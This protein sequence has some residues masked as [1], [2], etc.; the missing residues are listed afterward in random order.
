TP[1]YMVALLLS[2]ILGAA[3]VGSFHA[4][5]IGLTGPGFGLDAMALA[6]R[7][8]LRAYFAGQDIAYAVIAVPL[9]VA[10]SFALAAVAGHPAD[11]F[12]AAAVELAAIGAALG[13][14]SIFTVVLAYP[15]EKRAGSPTPRPVSGYAGRSVGATFA[16]LF[17]VAVLALPVLL[18]AALTGSDPAGVRMPVL[19]ACG[20]V[21]GLGLAWTGVTVAARTAEQRL[22]ELYQIAARSKL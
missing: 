9:L 6:G 4:N 2:A 13:L 11:G 10:V 1:N 17:S 14:V 21:W 15:V 19:V 18:G 3:F 20:A 5:S 22:P 7:R 16:T 12:L 8:A